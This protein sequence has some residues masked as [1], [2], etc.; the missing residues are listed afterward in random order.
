M[1]D[2]PIEKGGAKSARAVG[3]VGDEVVDVKGASG[4]KEIKDAKAGNRTDD[5]VQLEERQLI[6]FFLLLQTL[7]RRNRWP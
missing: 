2:E 3:I 1:F 6:P 5:P 7:A 4:E